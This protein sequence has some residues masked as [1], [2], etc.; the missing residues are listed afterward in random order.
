MWYK[1]A[2]KILTNG[3]AGTYHTAFS[4]YVAA[5][6]SD[7]PLKCVANSGSSVHVI[8]FEK[9]YLDAEFISKNEKLLVDLSQ[10]SLEDAILLAC[11]YL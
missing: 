1:I 7:A 3:D 10:K 8:R 5:N 11:M 2:H 6:L 4:V 9:F